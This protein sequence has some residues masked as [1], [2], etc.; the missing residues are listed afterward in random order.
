MCPGTFSPT[1]FGH[2]LNVV[3]D[4]RL[5]AP[6]RQTCVPGLQVHTGAPCGH[7]GELERGVQG[8]ICYPCQV[9]A[10]AGHVGDGDPSNGG[11]NWEG[12]INAEIKMNQMFQGERKEKPLPV[13]NSYA[14]RR[15]HE[16]SS[17]GAAPLDST[18]A[19][20]ALVLGLPLR[21]PDFPKQ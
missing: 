10:S 21:S 15:R 11:G 13:L 17:G 9:K 3:Q 16:R 5:Q 12:D 6:Q 7:Q 20:S 8:E 4:A 19:P 2:Y 1:C 18:P 14:Q